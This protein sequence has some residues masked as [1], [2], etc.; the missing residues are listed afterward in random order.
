MLPDCSN[1][2][3]THATC[4][5]VNPKDEIPPGEV[6]SAEVEV[7]ELT[8]VGLAAAATVAPKSRPPEATET[9]VEVP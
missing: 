8:G 9:A 3:Q 2:S 4:S 1:T 5:C 7:A 6:E